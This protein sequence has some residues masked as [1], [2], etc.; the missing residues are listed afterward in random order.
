[1]KKDNYNDNGSDVV[2]TLDSDNPLP[3]HSINKQQQQHFY[4]NKLLSVKNF[5]DAFE[6]VKSAVDDQFK[7]HRAGLSL[8]LQVLPTQLGAY[9]VLGSNMIIM[10]KRILDIIKSKKSLLE[11][12]SYLFMVLCHEYLHSFGIMDE[13]H[14]RRMTYNLCQSLLGEG[15]SASLM[16]RDQ[17]WKVFPELQLDQTNKFGNTFEIIKNFDKTTQ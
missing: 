12:N 17:P 3:S 8:V 16:A 11:Y 2:K 5:N 14:V 6:L 9:H 10:N 4:Q 7:M 1:M 13:I 15:H